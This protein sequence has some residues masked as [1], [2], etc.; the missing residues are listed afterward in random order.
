MPTSFSRKLGFHAQ[1]L[2][3]HTL[4]P[5]RLPRKVRFCKTRMRDFTSPRDPLTCNPKALAPFGYVPYTPYKS[6]EVETCQMNSRYG[7][8]IFLPPKRAGYLK[9]YWTP[10]FSTKKFL[11]I[12]ASY[13][14]FYL[15]CSTWILSVSG[16]DFRSF[17]SPD[18]DCV[19]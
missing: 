11:R 8:L 6:Q 5:A 9:I 7:P 18:R 15:F 2:I 17:R 3:L 4:S 14:E 12:R 13:W 10:F 19:P 16:D 1:S